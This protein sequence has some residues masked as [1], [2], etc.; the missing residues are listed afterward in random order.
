MNISNADSNLWEPFNKVYARVL[1]ENR[2]A[3][4]VIPCGPLHYGFLIEIEGDC[5]HGNLNNSLV[6]LNCFILV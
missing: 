5:R 6:N 4:A 2:P 1:G 3:R